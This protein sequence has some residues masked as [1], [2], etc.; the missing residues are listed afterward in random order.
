M[1]AACRSFKRANVYRKIGLAIKSEEACAKTLGD[2]S[3]R[4]EGKNQEG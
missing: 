1:S 4:R 3:R 2:K